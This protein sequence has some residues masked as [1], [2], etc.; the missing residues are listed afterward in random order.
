MVQNWLSCCNRRFR[1][2]CAQG[3]GVPPLEK[4]ACICIGA[5]SMIVHF[6]G[7]F[8]ALPNLHLLHAF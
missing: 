1:I 7:Q 2:Q 3:A 6:T 5:I 8:H 4:V